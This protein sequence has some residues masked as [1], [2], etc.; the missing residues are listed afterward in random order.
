MKIQPAWNTSLFIKIK[1]KKTQSLSQSEIWDKEEL[2]TII[3]YEQS[4]RNKVDLALFWN[5]DIRNYE[6]T[7]LKIK[8]IRL[9]EIW[10]YGNMEIWKLF[11][12]SQKRLY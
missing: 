12:L 2:L 7:L 10:K 9:S 3:K 11:K 6:I 1:L 5:L 4:K 8:N